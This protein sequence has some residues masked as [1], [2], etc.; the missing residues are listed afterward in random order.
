M[1]VQVYCKEMRPPLCTATSG[2]S[3]VNV[4]DGYSEILCQGKAAAGTHRP[5]DLHSQWHDII[6]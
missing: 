4:K 1:S 2:G 6:S 3:C 5:P